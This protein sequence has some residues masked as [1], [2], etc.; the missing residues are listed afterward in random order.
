MRAL[1]HAL[2]TKYSP[3]SDEQ[4]L[5]EWDEAAVIAHKSRISRD[6]PGA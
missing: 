6:V 3:T 5:T 4:R 1:T 2:A